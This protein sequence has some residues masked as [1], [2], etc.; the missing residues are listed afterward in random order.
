MKMSLPDLKAGVDQ[1][2]PCN[3]PEEVESLIARLKANPWPEGVEPCRKHY[4]AMNGKIDPQVSQRSVIV[5]DVPGM[6]LTPRLCSDTVVLFL[7]GGGYVF[8]SS[9]S[10]GGMAAQIALRLGCRVLVL[11]YQRAPEAPCPAAVEDAT[12]AYGWL[13]EH[14][15]DTENIAIVGDSA[16]GGL[17]IST[18]VALRESGQPLPA[19]AVC[20]SPWVDLSMSGESHV[21]RRGMDPAV[22]ESTVNFVAGAYLGNR[23]P[24]D[25]QASP[26]FADLAGLPPLLIQVGEREILYS[27]SVL[28]REKARAAG[29]EVTFEEW[30]GQ[31]HVW[32]F[33]YDA[34]QDAHRALDRISEFLSDRLLTPMAAVT[35]KQCV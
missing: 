32:H 18:L 24:Q 28:L 31:I 29:V 34:L 7:H 9:Q 27:D 8:G 14:R 33:Y 17:V 3:H 20:V 23:S 26:V 2:I 13:L 5:N 19:A 4:D 30:L 16:G 35:E 10:H 6:M 11:D 12:K 22:D 15:V 1:Q 25:M 21:S